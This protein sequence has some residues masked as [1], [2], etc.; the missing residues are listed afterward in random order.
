MILGIDPGNYQLRWPKGSPYLL[1]VRFS[2]GAGG[3]LDLTGRVLR[4]AA[5]RA[6][7]KVVYDAPIAIEGDTGTLVFDGSVSML[8]GLD[9]ASWQ[10][11]QV[12]DEGPTPL[13]R[14]SVLVTAAAADQGTGAG[15]P[16]SDLLTWEPATQTL[17]VSPIGAR[18]PSLSEELGTTPEALIADLVTGPV[19]DAITDLGEFTSERSAEI[20]DKLD[21]ADAAIEETEAAGQGAIAATVGAN[22]AAA[23]LLSMSTS[24]ADLL[25][26]GTILDASLPTSTILLGDM[27]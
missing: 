22:A 2:N 7:G 17:I 8:V 27:L 9:G 11:A 16:P 10:V 23:G 15:A 18:G 13:F 20:D 4:F 25:A 19:G 1:R 21:Q 12:F 3:F 14:G 26:P 6:S 5:Y 24:F